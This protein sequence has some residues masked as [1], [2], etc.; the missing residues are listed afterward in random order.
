MYHS[1]PACRKAALHNN[2]VD[3]SVLRH[4]K[5]SIERTVT[6]HTRFSTE[7]PADVLMEDL[8]AERGSIEFFNETMENH[9]DPYENYFSFDVLRQ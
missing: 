9:D 5:R 2:E 3:A 8:F 1:I 7:C 6:R 4:D